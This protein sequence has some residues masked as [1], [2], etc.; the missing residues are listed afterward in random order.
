M[1]GLSSRPARR[2]V[3]ALA[4]RLLVTHLE[5]RDCPAAP[6]V[7]FMKG[8]A[9]GLQADVVTAEVG[10]LPLPAPHRGGVASDPAMRT[11]CAV[12][13]T[14]RIGGTPSPQA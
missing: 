5:T 11:S 2:S 7:D 6:A 9:Q 13:A 4:S 12:T 14:V 1:I 8:G 3:G 10:V